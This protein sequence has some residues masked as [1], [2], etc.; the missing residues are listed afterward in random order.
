MFTGDALRWF[1][2][3]APLRLRMSGPTLGRMLRA[4]LGAGFASVNLPMLHGRTLARTR[5][6]EFRPGVLS[7]QSRIDLSDEMERQFFGDVMLFSIE[8]LS[9]AGYPACPLDRRQIAD[10]LDAVHAELSHK[11][12][13]R[14]AQISARLDELR[15][16]LHEPARWWNRTPGLDGTLNEFAA[17]VENIQHNFASQSSGPGLRDVLRVWPVWRERQLD[18]IERL[19]ADRRAWRRALAILQRT[20]TE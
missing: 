13:A 6:S 1:I 10:T 18:A 8:R 9:A 19:P 2:P 15:A 12:Q 14:R 4:E 17:F 7:E 16:V 11:Y 20:D 5:V 3:F